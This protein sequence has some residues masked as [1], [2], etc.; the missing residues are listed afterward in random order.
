MNHNDSMSGRA[1]K[2]QSQTQVQTAAAGEENALPEPI[3]AINVRPESPALGTARSV[4]LSANNPWL[5]VLPQDPKR[6]DAVLL[7]VDN[8]VYVT[9]SREI[10]MEIAGG[11]TGVDAFYLPVGIGIPF[12]AKC[13]YWVAATTTNTSSLVS[14]SIVKDD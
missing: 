12:G 8:D 6:R 5:P 14:V 10:A 4:T 13:A 11:N 9:T 2:Y 7:A 3:P 1:A